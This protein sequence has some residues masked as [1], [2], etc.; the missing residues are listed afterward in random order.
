MAR[1]A[2]I[3]LLGVLSAWWTRWPKGRKWLGL[4]APGKKAALGEVFV[5]SG[6]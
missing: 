4:S 5:L 1:A 6:V 3:F 2:S